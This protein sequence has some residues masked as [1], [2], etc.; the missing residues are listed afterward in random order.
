[1]LTGTKTWDG[2]SVWSFSGAAAFTGALCSCV[3]R[4][5]R[6]WEERGCQDGAGHSWAGQIP[7][8]L[9]SLFNKVQP[10]ALVGENVVRWPTVCRERCC[11]R[12]MHI[13]T[14]RELRSFI[15]N[16]QMKTRYSRW[17][18]MRTHCDFVKITHMEFKES[19][20]FI[21]Y[22]FTRTKGTRNQLCSITV[23]FF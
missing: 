15:S 19:L 17:G 1:M 11:W 2:L 22:I 14:Y 3:V 23:V 13:I 20:E 12:W 10:A 18:V 4:G 9:F 21:L 6:A 8:S 5:W 7:M 16:I